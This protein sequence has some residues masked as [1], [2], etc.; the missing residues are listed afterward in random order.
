MRKALAAL[1]VLILVSLPIQASAAVKA[2]AT[3]TKAGTTS[4]VQGIKYTCVKSG[5]KLVW[6]KGVKVVVAPTPSPTPTV[7][8]TPTPTP[9]P[10]VT[11]TPTP[12][13]T[14]TFNSLWEK[15][16]LTKPTSVDEVIKKSTD[17]FK[18]YT[19]VVRN[20]EQEIKFYSQTGVDET[21][22]TWVKEGAT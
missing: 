16:D 4:T 18:S 1:T 2:G 19:S 20:S 7:T 11:A 13:P 14:K 9:T 15:Y 8:A 12:T 5:K 17:N 3:C 22:T 21:L 10:T 6:N